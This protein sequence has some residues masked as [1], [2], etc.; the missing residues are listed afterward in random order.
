MLLKD[1][2]RMGSVAKE[3]SLFVSLKGLAA[4]TN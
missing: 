3:K 1:Y 2:D 4:N